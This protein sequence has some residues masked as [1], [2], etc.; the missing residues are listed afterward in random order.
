MSIIPRYILISRITLLSIL[1]ISALSING[2]SQD[3]E[4]PSYLYEDEF[5]LGIKIHA[6]GWGISADKVHLKTIFKQRIIRIQLINI[7]HPREFKQPAVNGFGANSTNSSAFAYGK[8]NSFHTVNVGIGRR[9]MIGEKGRRNGIEISYIYQL[10]ASLG[11]LNPY[12]LDIQEDFES[13]PIKYSI[14]TQN[15]FLDNSK[16]RGYSGYLHSLNE[17]KFIPGIQGQ[18]SLHF[19]YALFDQFVNTVEAGILVQA[20]YKRVPIMVTE[21][22]HLVFPNLFLKFS[23]GRRK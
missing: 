6:N 13:T 10:G 3:I 18:F 12:Y 8:I 4:S 5:S 2:Y 21:D 16:I 9:H 1:F 22:N 20:F 14:E 15:V 19:D 7:K 17:I 23:I 11:L